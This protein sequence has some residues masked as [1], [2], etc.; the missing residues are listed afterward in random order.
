MIAAA[1]SSQEEEYQWM[2]TRTAR[3]DTLRGL[4]RE[5]GITTG[6]AARRAVVYAQNAASVAECRRLAQ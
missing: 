6:D 1:D 2:T 5:F 3:I 4:M